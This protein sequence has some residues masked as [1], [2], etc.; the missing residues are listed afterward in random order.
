[1]PVAVANCLQATEA[2]ATLCAVCQ[3]GYNL[4]VA[5]YACVGGSLREQCPSK[6]TGT[7]ANLLGTFIDY[8]YVGFDGSLIDQTIVMSQRYRADLTSPYSG[9]VFRPGA[10]VSS[11]SVQATGIGG[12]SSA[13]NNGFTAEVIATGGPTVQDRPHADTARR[14]GRL[15]TR[16]P[17]RP[18]AHSVAVSSARRHGRGRPS[19]VHG[20]QRIGPG[21]RL[22][23]RI[24]RVRRLG[25]PSLTRGCEAALPTFT[26]ANKG[27][28]MRLHSQTM[29][30]TLAPALPGFLGGPTDLVP[31]N[32]TPMNIYGD[33]QKDS[34]AERNLRVGVREH[35]MGI[36]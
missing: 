23:S 17:S 1:M 18:V 20:I 24:Q 6:A 4:T 12:T 9:D 26:P 8:F 7:S 30:N 22:G 36:N 32:M 35:A 28:A 25:S 34:Y 14:R 10:P 5:A 13:A 21:R 3:V 11:W 16:P 2:S 31:S 19:P 27:L 29:L 15:P 33:F